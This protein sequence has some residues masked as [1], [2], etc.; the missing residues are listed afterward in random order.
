[1]AVRE[2]RDRKT[3]ELLAVRADIKTG[4]YEG[5]WRVT[6]EWDDVEPMFVVTKYEATRF[7]IFTGNPITL[8]PR[9]QWTL[10]AGT[11]AE[12][13]DQRVTGDEL[14][15]IAEEAGLGRLEGLDD[16]VIFNCSR[17]ELELTYLL[18]AR[19]AKAITRRF[20]AG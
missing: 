6:F 11:A 17:L 18:G 5:H 13:I 2:E 19:V 12:Q 7:D 15:T 10:P 1:M 8:E 3:G 9:D 14:A 16:M 4:R 20:A